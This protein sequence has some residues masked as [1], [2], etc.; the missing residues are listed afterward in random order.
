M[1]SSFSFLRTIAL[2]KKGK[3]LLE[4][5][6]LSWK[7]RREGGEG[8]RFPV[9]PGPVVRRAFG[10]KARADLKHSPGHSLSGLKGETASSNILLRPLGPRL[11]TLPYLSP[12]FQVSLLTSLSEPNAR[13][14]RLKDIFVGLLCPCCF[15]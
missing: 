12:A 11:G 8:I 5:M 10:D 4:T 9:L 14:R 2:A 6:H 15:S 3:G 7:I 13:G 1:K